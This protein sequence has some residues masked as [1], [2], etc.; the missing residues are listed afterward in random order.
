MLDLA[1]AAVVQSRAHVHGSAMRGGF[2]EYFGGEA[3]HH[4]QPAAAVAGIVGGAPATVVGDG[5]QQL[6]LV[7]LSL[8][9]HHRV[10]MMRGVGVFDRIGQC[11]IDRQGEIVD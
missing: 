8:Q 3:A 1:V 2:E 4:G 11:F 10:G 6:V 5:D 9:V 7:E